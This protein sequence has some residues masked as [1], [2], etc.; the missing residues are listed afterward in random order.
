MSILRHSLV[1]YVEMNLVKGK[2]YYVD[3][4]KGG[5]AK[6]KVEQATVK[7]REQVRETFSQITAVGNTSRLTVFSTLLNISSRGMR[8]V[9]LKWSFDIHKTES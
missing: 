6:G 5:E 1:A 2:G 8:A 4:E 9:E 7:E 3:S